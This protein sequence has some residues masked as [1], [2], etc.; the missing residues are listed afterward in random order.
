MP[1]G[2]WRDLFR[3]RSVDATL[4][5]GEESGFKRSL[6]ATDLTGIGIAA[7]IGSGIFFLLGHEARSTGPAVI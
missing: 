6:G 3:R 4:Q 7:I 5:A 2:G 1:E